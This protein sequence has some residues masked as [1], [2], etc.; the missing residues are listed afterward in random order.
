VRCRTAHLALLIFSEL[1]HK[2]PFLAAD[3]E[4]C[5]TPL[6]MMA[7]GG[8]HNKRPCGGSPHCGCCQPSSHRARTDASSS[9]ASPLVRWVFTLCQCLLLCCDAGLYFLIGVRL[10]LLHMR[11][12]SSCRGS[13]LPKRGSWIAEKVPLLHGR[14]DWWP[15][16]TP[17]ERCTRNV[18]QVTSELRLSSRTPSPKC[19][20]LATGPNSSPTST[21]H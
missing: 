16:S 21:G 15:L 11:W 10:R 4:A 12:S 9:R 8:D 1:G 13:S 14:M 5:P 17:L 2:L 18:T 7:S 19:V 6:P 20:S 3:L